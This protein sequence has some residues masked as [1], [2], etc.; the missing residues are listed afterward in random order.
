MQDKKL[1]IVVSSFYKFI[2]VKAIFKKF[3]LILQ[4]EI[5]VWIL[6][7]KYISIDIFQNIK[8]DCIWQKID[9]L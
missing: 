8:I 1:K 2:H 7:N 4:M 5:Y 6:I 9:I 3:Q